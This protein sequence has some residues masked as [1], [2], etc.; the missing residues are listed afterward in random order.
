[1]FS[2]FM[3]HLHHSFIVSSQNKPR[4]NPYAWERGVE[5]CRELGGATCD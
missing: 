4:W 5:K 2:A 1:M 3:I